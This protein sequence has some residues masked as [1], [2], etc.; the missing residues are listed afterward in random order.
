MRLLFISICCILLTA[1]ESVKK[2]ASNNLGNEVVQYTVNDKI[3]SLQQGQKINIDNFSITYQSNINQDSTLKFLSIPI[4][5]KNVQY[6]L[7]IQDTKQS[8]IGY[9]VLVS[10][11]ALDMSKPILKGI[12]KISIAEA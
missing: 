6:A 7:S 5:V 1:C 3:K 2:V 11:A 8:S 9:N 12:L 4:E 10:A